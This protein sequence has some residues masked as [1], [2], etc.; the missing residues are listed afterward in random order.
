MHYLLAGTHGH[1][2]HH[3]PPEFDDTNPRVNAV[4]DAGEKQQQENSDKDPSGT[5]DCQNCEHCEANE[6]NNNNNNHQNE[7]DASSETFDEG[8]A[9]IPVCCAH[10]PAGQWE[11]M[12]EMTR[13]IEEEEMQG[14]HDH[15]HGFGHHH[16]QQNN[17]RRDRETEDTT[18]TQDEDD[19][20]RISK[21]EAK[22]LHMMSL[23]TA[24]AIAL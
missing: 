15:K 19:A 18:R 11:K 6:E 1:H 8:E 21:E 14:I 2:H 5:G 9:P 20:A 7:K 4:A 24:I 13:T 22:K 3:D 23:N 17:K 10:D 12:Q 16:Q